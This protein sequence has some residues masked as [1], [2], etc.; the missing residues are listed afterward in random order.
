MIEEYLKSPDRYIKHFAIFLIALGVF[1][2]VMIILAI[3]NGF[4]YSGGSLIYIYGGIKLLNKN[5]KVYNIVRKYI[6]FFIPLTLGALVTFL[7]LFILLLL[8]ESQVFDFFSFFNI[9]LVIIFGLTCLIIFTTVLFWKKET[10][11]HFGVTENNELKITNGLIICVPQKYIK[12]IG[13]GI[14][15]VTIIFLGP[16][17]Y[18]NPYLTLE[19]NLKNS[20]IVREQVGEVKRIKIKSTSI[21]NWILVSEIEVKG[22]KNTTEYSVKVNANTNEIDFN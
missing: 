16:N 6:L 9:S 5:K 3:I 1:D 10:I 18:E 4:S 21:F 8:T 11:N 15:I 12:L 20:K 14:I 19:Y 22:D 2:T 13:I 7:Y 17:M